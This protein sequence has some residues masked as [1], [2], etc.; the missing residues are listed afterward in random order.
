MKILAFSDLHRDADA[1]RRIVKASAAADVLIGAGDFATR[2]EGAKESLA[3]LKSAG[4]P[5]VIVSGNHDRLSELRA[6]C[7]GW[8]NGFL[9]HGEGIAFDGIPFFGLGGEIPR[10]NEADW[11]EALS[12]TRAATMLATCP[13]QAVLITHTP[14]LGTGDKQRDGTHEG[15]EAILAVINDKRPRLVLCGHIHHGWGTSG[16]VG[17]TPVH[18]LGPTIN[19]FEI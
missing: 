17:E 18:N 16:T 10:R 3:I 19:W 2:G 6:L 13:E 9:L 4:L 11:N 1:A 8:Q 12:E 7:A 14:P 5:T 15:S